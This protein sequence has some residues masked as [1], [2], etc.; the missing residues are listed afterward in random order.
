MQKL[1]FRR[2]LR[3]LKANFFRY[4][5]LFLL[6]VFAMSIVIGIVGSAESVIGSVNAVAE[7]TQ[8]ED[9][10]FGVFV[11]LQRGTVRD[12]EQ[13]GVKLEEC[14]SLDFSVEDGST[15]RVMK[16]RENINL[17]D[18]AEGRLAQSDGEIVLERLYAAAHGISVGDS[19]AL[20]GK[21]YTVTGIGTTSDY[22]LCLQNQSDMSADG[23]TFGTAFVPDDVYESLRSGGKALH[24]E[25]YRY[26][27]RL[28]GSFTDSKLKD[29]LSRLKISPDEVNDALF[30]EMVQEK[31]G[32]RDEAADGIQKVADGSGKLEDASKKLESGTA[33]LNDGIQAA[34]GGLKKL[35]GESQNLSGGSE[36]VLAAL[37]ELEAGSGKLSFS[38]SSIRQLSDASLA[39]LSG[40]TELSGK[41]QVLSDKV[42]VSDF[43]TVMKAAFSRQGVDASSLSPDAQILLNTIEGYLN[44]VHGSLAEAADGAS[45]LQ[46]SL[47]AFDDTMESLPETIKSLNAGVRQLQSAFSEL[48]SEYTLL[49]SGIG[50]YTDSLDRIADGFAQIADGSESL[51]KGARA[52]AENGADF[53]SG[54]LTL[55]EKTDDLLNEYFPF[56]IENMT[57]FIKAS[58]NPRIKASSGDVE[59]NRSVGTM[60]GV[61]VMVL[62]T[63]V[64]SI[65]VV[66]SIEQESA[67]IGALYALGL[68]RKQ[69]TNHYT[70]LPVLLCLTGGI[71]GT[72]QGY[73]SL[74]ISLLAKESIDYYS[75]PAIHAV[76]SPILLIYGLL[77]PPLIALLVN[78]LIIRKKL[79]RS[80]LSLLRR[81]QPYRNSAGR[82][83]KMRSF[84]RTFQI[85]QV[86]REKRSCFAVLAGMFVSL[87]ILVLGLNCYS[88]C[89]NAQV[90]NVADTKYEYLYQYKYPTKTPPE[91]GYEAYVTSLK[92]EVLGYDMEVNVIGLTDDN[93]FFPH[94]SSNQTDEISIS[95]SVAVKYGVRTGD[96][97]VLQ[98]EVNDK[99][100]AFKV[101]EIVPYSPGLCCFMNLDSM[102]ELFGQEEDYYNVVYSNHALKVDTGRLYAVSTKAGVKKS[103]DVFVNIMDS[104]VVTLITSAVLIFLIV[105][106]QIMK[107]M[108]DR[109]ATSISLMK[110]FGYR[111]REIR[112]LYLDGNF[113]LVAVGA[114]FMIPIAKFLMDAAY[115]YFI[116]NVACGMD[117]TW[118]PLLY[119][120]TYGGILLSYLL[121]R[122]LLMRKLKRLTPAEVLKDR[123]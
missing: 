31:T 78:R 22:D 36:S 4:L 73:S 30:Q 84:S 58:D 15:L 99:L 107:V 92:K 45:S 75:T 27:Y 81:E 86:L 76:Y 60:A 49:D 13:K 57:D 110:I 77:M 100:Y 35:A 115:P 79:N 17:I 96:Q 109:S 112:K 26:S 21:V 9:G 43:E 118:K 5:A 119:L 3:E 41:L 64:I 123:E 44:K 61:I 33:K 114:L 72:L 93:P 23:K 74:G 117:L 28:T 88:L 90:Q 40:A 59:I 7:Q 54:V 55:Q 56:E 14:F 71:V 6:I 11:P 8:L 65:F 102:R 104:M 106:Y 39:L 68:N 121:I 52:F 113:L 53:R 16:N 32:D 2:T 122:T 19:I 18:L 12:L 10:E 116:A 69:L 120:L 37:K 95:S 50:S 70:A 83:L 46:S 97:L 24:A 98:D 103:A 42:G 67:M 101:R 34:Y 108:I 89:Q 63:Y 87:L 48:R 66:H 29:D 91:G 85:R 82:R 1:F 80:A 62:I 20:G 94:I 25:K 47:K 111:G 51:N 105:L 38:V